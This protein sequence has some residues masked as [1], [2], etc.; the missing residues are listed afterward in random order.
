M[1]VAHVPNFVPQWQRT[2][3]PYKGYAIHVFI[4][5]TCMLHF[6]DGPDLLIKGAQ[7][8]PTMSRNDEDYIMRLH[9]HL[10][11]HW[12]NIYE[13]KLMLTSKRI[14]FLTKLSDEKERDCLPTKKHNWCK[15][16]DQRNLNLP[17]WFRV[18]RLLLGHLPPCPS[19][20]ASVFWPIAQRQCS[21][22]DKPVS[23]NSEQLCTLFRV[24]I[25]YDKNYNKP[26][27]DVCDGWILPCP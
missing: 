18:Y 12:T 2:V 13:L 7:Q 25:R 23:S 6:I 14:T 9:D 17:R 15:I 1:T 10:F 26:L 21:D 24:S 20:D 8:R 11:L 4:I 19:K 16:T 22:T 5:W 3:T 27:C